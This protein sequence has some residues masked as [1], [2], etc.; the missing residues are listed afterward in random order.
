VALTDTETLGKLL[1]TAENNVKHIS[2]IPECPA[3]PNMV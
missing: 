1:E 3:A 2:L